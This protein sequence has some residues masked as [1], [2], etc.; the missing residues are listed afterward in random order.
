MGS[1]HPTY[2]PYTTMAQVI[3]GDR[4]TGQEIRSQNV[5]AAVSVANIVRTSLG[6]V[7]LDKMM[8]DDIGDVTITNDGATIL[9]QLEVEHPAAKVLVEL[10]DLQDQE[11]GDGT[12][13]VVIIAAELLKRANIL[14]KHKIHPTSVIAGYR[15]AMRES[16]KYIKKN[17]T[18]AADTLGRE[19][20]L[21]AAR[22]SMSSK[23]I[24]TDS[25]FF[26]E[27][28]VSAVTQVR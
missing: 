19:N 15:L 27:M 9:K 1:P 11:V 12:T 2:T 6:P 16:V 3:N 28:V 26:A 7:G 23:I 4:T 20:L 17:L 8:V 21:N 5:Q 22:T 24:G 18:I 10:S 13:S 14:V 25:D